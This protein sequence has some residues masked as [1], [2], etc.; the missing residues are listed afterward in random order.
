MC[1]DSSLASSMTPRGREVI[2]TVHP[3]PMS[4]DRLRSITLLAEAMQAVPA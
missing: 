1:A 2:V 3:A 4:E